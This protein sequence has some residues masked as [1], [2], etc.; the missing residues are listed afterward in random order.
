MLTHRIWRE[1]SY[2]QQ[3]KHGEWIVSLRLYRAIVKSDEKSAERRSMKE[4]GRRGI[5][6]RQ[7]EGAGREKNKE[8]VYRGIRK[9]SAVMENSSREYGLFSDPDSLFSGSKIF[10]HVHQFLFVCL[11][12]YFPGKN[13]WLVWNTAG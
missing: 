6:G 1:T 5:Q 9:E 3:L 2:S 12:H 10:H 4:A 11:F 8:S 13:T 7:W